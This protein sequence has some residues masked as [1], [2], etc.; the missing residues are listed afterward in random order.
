MATKKQIA[1]NRR[2]A[3]KS[4]GPRTEKGK[5]AVRLNA[6]RHGLRTQPGMLPAES[7]NELNQIRGEFLRLFQPQ[8]RADVRL[9]HRMACAHWQVINLQRAESQ[10]LSESFQMSAASRHHSVEAFSRRLA[11]YQRAFNNALDL[12]NHSIRADP[13]P[14]PRPAA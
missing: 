2:N 8:S 4:T 5:A 10:F 3:L 6:L 9:V 1:A 11:R 12:Y 14:K 13:Q 7:L